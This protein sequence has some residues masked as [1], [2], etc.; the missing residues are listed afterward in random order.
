MV[1]FSQVMIRTKLKVVYRLLGMPKVSLKV[2]M[3]AGQLSYG[4]EKGEY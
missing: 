1:S 3:F 2:S 4:N